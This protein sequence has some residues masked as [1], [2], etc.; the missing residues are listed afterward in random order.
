MV[1][2]ATICYIDNGKKFYYFI[3]IKSLMIF[4]LASGLVL[5]VK[6]KHHWKLARCE[7]SLKRQDCA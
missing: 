1:K 6:L 3:A 5:V 7:K 2:L 4:M